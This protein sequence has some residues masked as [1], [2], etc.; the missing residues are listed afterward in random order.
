MYIMTRMKRSVAARLVLAVAAIV[1]LSGCATKSDVRDLQTQM[2]AELRD[3]AERQ[4]AL[5]TT[6]E[7]ESRSTQDTLRTQS[8]QIFDFRGEITRQMREISRSLTTIEALTGEN[9]RGI[10]GVRDQLANLR[11]SQVAR[12][13]A[14]TATDPGNS[15]VGGSGGDADQLYGTAVDMLNRGSLATASMAFRDFL[16]G[17]PN[18]EFAPDAYFN[19]ADILYQQENL[20]DALDAFGEIRSRFPTSEKVPDALYRIAQI[21]VEMDDTDDAIETL[22]RIVNTYPGTVIAD[23]AS[24]LLADIGQ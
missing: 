15:L 6:L 16:S 4:E 21:Q 18:H 2:L 9:Q 8:N 23:M 1:M 24:D 5:I 13:P 20:E 7:L 12:P 19:L 22:E 17:H 11:R 14:S 3:L 10:S